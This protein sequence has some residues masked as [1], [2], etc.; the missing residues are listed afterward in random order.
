MSYA[1]FFLSLLLLY[2]LAVYLLPIRRFRFE[3]SEAQ[4][5]KS[6]PDLYLYSYEL[7]VHTQFSYDSLGKPQDIQRAME[8]EG[9]DFVIA[10]DHDNDHIKHFAGD[11]I[12]AGI[13]K[14]INDQQGKLLGDLL[15][16]GHHRVIAHPFKEKYRWRLPYKDEYFFELVNLKDALLES[17]TRLFFFL[18]AVVFLAFFSQKRGL[19]L[20]KKL[21]RVEEYVK[22]YLSLGIKNRVVGGLDHHVKVYIR[23]VGVR[24]LFPCYRHSFYLMRNFLLTTEKLFTK[25]EFVKH[26]AKAFHVIAFT[27]KPT[28]VWKENGYVKVFPPKRCLLLCTGE[29]YKKAYLGDYFELKHKQERTFF[30]GYT[31]KLRFGRWFVG[32]KPMFVF[33]L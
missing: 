23:E 15:E 22:K 21:L 6:L 7:H 30:V 14:K 32:L 11:R 5:P 19:E 18:P 2:C 20:L 3:P 24:F 26:F 17:K 27:E 16:F 28:L 25:E 31:Y 13:E 4:L 8:Q 33:M 12:I 9:I 29:G 10:T 1:L